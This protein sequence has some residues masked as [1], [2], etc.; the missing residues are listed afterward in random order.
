MITPHQ[1]LIR[2]AD[3]VR[4]LTEPWTHAEPHRVTIGTH[5]YPRRHVTNH[6]SLLDQ[7]REMADPSNG[8]IPGGPRGKP[9]PSPAAQLAATHLLATITREA[10]EWLTFGDVAVRATLEENI[11]ALVGY[12]SS[13]DDP[14]QL[15]GAVAT[16]RSRIRVAVG[17]DSPAFRPAARCPVIKCDAPPGDGSGLRI[18][19][20][21]DVAWCVSCG[22]RWSDTQPPFIGMLRRHCRESV[23]AT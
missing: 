14:R 12:A 21:G 23:E 5:S 20:D 6:P 13:V 3:H 7:L 10:H 2:M 1:A 17:W 15:S 22:T 4:E 19:S 18:R 8:K 11:R 9:G 16:W